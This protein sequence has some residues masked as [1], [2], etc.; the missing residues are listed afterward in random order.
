MGAV[1]D[2][3]LIKGYPCSSCGASLEFAP[4]TTSMEC[5]YCG[6]QNEIDIDLSEIEERDLEELPLLAATTDRGMGV[7]QRHFRCE[8]CGAL[9]GIEPAAIAIECVYCGSPAIV[10]APSNPD[11][12]RPAALVPFAFDEKAARGKY[13]RWLGGRWRRIISPGSLKNQAVVRKI[14]GVYT[15]FFTFDAQA[16]SDWSGNRGDYYYVT[17]GF[18]VDSQTVRKTE[19]TYQVGHHSH[20]YDDVLMY[21][22]EALPLKRLRKVMPFQ[23]KQVVPYSGEFLAGFAAE[24]YTLDPEDL[25]ETARYS[26]KVQEWH[27]CRQ[28]LGGDEQRN[29]RV[30]THLMDPTWKHILLPLYVAN[31]VF[32]ERHYR[33]LVNGQTGK[34]KGSAPISWAKVGG[35]VA[36]AVAATLGIAALLG[37]F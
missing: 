11:L 24:E 34:V 2:A 4:G 26:M 10:E 12:V 25:W 35:I 3:E 30:H 9:Q 15:P 28:E 31:Y 27:A 14:R 36:I 23:T 6:A 37:V 19:W 29:L 5:P 13:R 16:E 32:G 20:F 7:E 1:G 21:A 17:E 18:G 22:S 33:F 8:R